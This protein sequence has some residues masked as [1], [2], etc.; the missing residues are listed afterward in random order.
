M[1]CKNCGA[2]TTNN[3]TECPKCGKPLETN[4]DTNKW[5]NEKNKLW[6]SILFWPLF[7]YG[8]IKTEALTKKTKRIIL[9]CIIAFFL[10]A[11]VSGNKYNQNHH[12]SSYD[13]SSGNLSK[14]EIKGIVEDY[15]VPKLSPNHYEGGLFDISMGANGTYEVTHTFKVSDNQGNVETF[16]KIFYIS[17]SGKVVGVQSHP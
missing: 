14:A 2:E 10:L 1:Y 12:L 17:K 16:F 3:A 4:P 9:G 6:L 13:N 7:V 15:L 11:I 5:Y 8:V